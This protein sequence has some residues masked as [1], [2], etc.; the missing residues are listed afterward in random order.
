MPTFPSAI[1]GALIVGAVA[2]LQFFTGNL[3]SFG[4]SDLYAP[5]A[6]IVA[7][8]LIKVLQERAPES[9]PRSISEPERPSYWQRVLYK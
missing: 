8:T 1:T 7:N 6:V 3:S 5:I 4:I 9:T 2:I